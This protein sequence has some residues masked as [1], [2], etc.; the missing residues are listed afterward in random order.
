MRRHD[1][2]HARCDGGGERHQFLLRQDAPAYRQSAANRC[3]D[4]PRHRR[5]RGNVW[6]RRECLL[7]RGREGRRRPCAR[8]FRGS[9]PKL[10]PEV[11]GLA[12]LVAKSSMGAKSRLTPAARSSR[13][14][15]R[16]TCSTSATSSSA[17]SSLGEGQAVKGGCKREARAAAFLIDANQ[18][19]LFGGVPDGIGECPQADRIVVI[20]RNRL[21]RRP[22][23]MRA[24]RPFR[25][26]VASPEKPS[27]NRSSTSE[28]SRRSSGC[29]RVF[30]RHFA[31]R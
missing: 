11:T 9:A 24:G 14:M 30:L 26:A 21:P 5:G 7:P 17:P 22:S 20:A 16:A 13:A 2:G 31:R 23:R 15:A 25:R 19:G 18:Y 28:D 6:R 1:G 29:N 3:G 12:G 8:R 27:T 4:P 10:R